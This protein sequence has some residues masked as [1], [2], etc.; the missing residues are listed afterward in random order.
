M[1]FK[2]LFQ[3]KFQV[4]HVFFHCLKHEVAFLPQ[5]P[6]AVHCWS[7][8]QKRRLFAARITQ[9]HCYGVKTIGLPSLNY[10]YRC[11]KTTVGKLKIVKQLTEGYIYK[12]IISPIN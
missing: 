1:L 4:E 6:V 2:V 10:I 5:Q 7:H 12:Q 3:R 11:F 9:K 8:L